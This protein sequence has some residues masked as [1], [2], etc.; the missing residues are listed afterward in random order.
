[1]RKIKMYLKN[2]RDLQ[3]RKAD[4][5]CQLINLNLDLSLPLSDLCKLLKAQYPSLVADIQAYNKAKLEFMRG[6]NL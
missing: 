6:F 2:L 5:A 1:M 3:A 4:L